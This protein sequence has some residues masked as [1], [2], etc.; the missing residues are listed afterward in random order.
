MLYKPLLRLYSHLNGRT[1][2]SNKT[3]TSV[4]KV[5]VVCIGVHVSR[6]LKE[7]LTWATY[8]QVRVI[9]I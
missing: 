7:E 5:G 9:V 6:H 3:N 2:V 8:E 1:Y 4:I